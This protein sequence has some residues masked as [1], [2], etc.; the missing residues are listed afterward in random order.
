MKSAERG[1]LQTHNLVMCKKHKDKQ[2]GPGAGGSAGN[3]LIVSTKS[4][5]TCPQGNS[6]QHIQF[7][8][9]ASQNFQ[10][11]FRQGNFI[12]HGSRRSNDMSSMQKQHS[13]NPMGIQ[14]AIPSFTQAAQA[15]LAPTHSL[16][17]PHRHREESRQ[18]Q[19][20]GQTS[21]Q[22]SPPQNNLNP[23]MND[24]LQYLQQAYQ[25]QQDSM[26]P[27]A[28][29]GHS[30]DARR[31]QP[32]EEE[33]TGPFSAQKNKLIHF[34]KGDRIIYEPNEMHQLKYIN[35]KGEI[36]P[37]TGVQYIL[38]QPNFS[39]GRPCHFFVVNKQEFEAATKGFQLRSEEQKAEELA[40]QKKMQA[41]HHI[42]SH[43]TSQKL[44]TH[45]KARRF[46]RKQSA[47]GARGDKDK[48][49]KDKHKDTGCKAE[50]N[51]KEEKDKYHNE[52]YT[53]QKLRSLKWM[54]G[55]EGAPPPV[56]RSI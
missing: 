32:V 10:K 21:Q 18:Q 26:Q 54:G 2:A 47:K 50:E 20:A 24:L 12:Y 36:S 45:S 6:R 7:Q 3:G 19:Q 44:K 35:D 16:G 37:I 43:R 29:G 1:E 34:E 8:S 5:C 49:A 38:T 39:K 27:P 48:E 41:A 15:T 31:K 4:P 53:Y 23:L 13:S 40:K 30:A 11:T 46:D 25:N 14:P 56:A 9:K 55:P 51:K 52:I 22:T 17:P 42:R 33:S 28:G